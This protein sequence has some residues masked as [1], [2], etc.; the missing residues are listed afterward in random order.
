MK[1]TLCVIISAFTLALLI[2]S[3]G[4]IMSVKADETIA[5]ENMFRRA[6]LNPNGPTPEEMNQSELQYQ[7]RLAGG[8]INMYGN[9][10]DNRSLKLSLI[11]R[12]LDGMNISYKIL[13]D[14]KILLVRKSDGKIKYDVAYVISIDEDILSVTG[15]PEKDNSSKSIVSLLKFC[16][17]YNHQKRW[18]TATVDEDDHQIM[19]YFHVRFGKKFSD[20]HLKITL[21]LGLSCMNDLYAEAS[22]N[23]F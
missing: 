9:A 5:I 7:R 12:I 8:S 6:G 11:E 23:G 14:E 21:F 4:C 17:Q 18:P 20:E 19:G 22:S 16:N 13:S 15:L 3:A 10:P 1:K 2:E